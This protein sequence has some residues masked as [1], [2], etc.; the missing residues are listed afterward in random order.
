MVV[1]VSAS[2]AVSAV[3]SFAH[4]RAPEYLDLLPQGDASL[5]SWVQPSLPSEQPPQGMSGSPV[6]TMT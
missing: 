6:T 3:I 4:Q 2:S 1:S 5:R